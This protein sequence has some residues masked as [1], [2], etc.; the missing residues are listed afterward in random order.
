MLCVFKKLFAVLFVDKTYS[1]KKKLLIASIVNLTFVF[2]IFIF[3]PF[4]TFFANIEE[5]TFTFSEFW[6][7]IVLMGGV[8]FALLL[9]VEMLFKGKWFG[10]VVSLVFGGTLACYV[11][12]MFLNG[13]MKTLDGS[14]DNWSISQKIINIIIWAVVALL[15][16]VLVFFGKTLWST[17]CKWGSA[18]IA[19]MQIV[20]LITMALTTPT[21]TFDLRITTDGMYEVAKKDNVIIFVLDRFDQTHVDTIMEKQ[22]DF[23]NELNGFTYYPNTSGSYIFTHNTLPFML[24]GIEMA[25]FYPTTEMKSNA[26]ENS[27]YLKFIRQNTGFMGLYTS[28]TVLDVDTAAKLEYADNI[29]PLPTTTNKQMFAKAAIKASFYR[30]A[31]FVFKSRFEYTSDNFNAAVSAADESA[32]FGNGSHYYDAL[33]FEELKTSGLLIDNQHHNAGF[34]LIHTMGAHYPYNLTENGEYSEIET[35]QISSCLGEFRILFK[36][37]DEL[38][39]LGVYDDATIIITSDHGDTRIDSGEE[40]TPNHCPIMFYKATGN[41][42][43]HTFKTSLAPVS[44]M[45]IFPTVIKALG[46]DTSDLSQYGLSFDGIPIDELTEKTKRTRYFYLGLQDPKI[47]DRQ[48]CISVEMKTVGDARVLKNWEETGRKVYTKNT[49]HGF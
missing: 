22:P 17:L 36:Y 13:M 43:N 20:A 25:D 24:T 12:S 48:S 33:M 34:R 18:L 29:K 1:I 40:R 35:D 5:F 4:E 47:I 42:E 16:V 30:V 2:S 32:L 19:G 45:D 14:S 7:P 11:Q 8:I 39:R 6:L 10:A 38:K 44:H 15:P 28:D 9:L 27:K 26:I 31:P 3:I 37:F 46:G 49:N 21:V 41:G 23:F